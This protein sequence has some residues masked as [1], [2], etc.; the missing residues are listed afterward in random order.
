MTITWSKQWTNCDWKVSFLLVSFSKLPP[1]CDP[2]LGHTWPS[3][4]EE[5]RRASCLPSR[6]SSLPYLPHLPGRCTT[7]ISGSPCTRR[8]SRYRGPISIRCATTGRPDNESCGLPSRVRQSP[9]STRALSQSPHLWVHS[10]RWPREKASKSEISFLSPRGGS[11]GSRET[12]RDREGWEGVRWCTCNC[13][14]WHAP[15]L[16]A[17]ATTWCEC[18]TSVHG[19]AGRSWRILFSRFR[20]R[21]TRGDPFTSLRRYVDL[22]P[23]CIILG[24]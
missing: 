17:D 13:T 7:G 5:D 6:L 15:L 23:R 3:H 2:Y 10:E 8:W 22:R 19:G 12:D 1:Q 20:F 18:T 16:H 11:E 24:N 14:C 9:G 21:P 4:F